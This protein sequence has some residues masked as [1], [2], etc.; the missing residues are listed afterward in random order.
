MDKLFQCLEIVRHIAF[1]AGDDYRSILLYKIASQ[2]PFTVLRPFPNF[3]GGAA[4][5]WL[6]RNWISE[7]LKQSIGFEYAQKLEGYRTEM[8]A[9]IEGIR[10]ENQINQLRTS[11][12]FDHT[13]E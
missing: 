12:F 6:F 11:L 8:N 9:K 4:I 10:H 7:R 3:V 5:V 1:I 13:S 2:E